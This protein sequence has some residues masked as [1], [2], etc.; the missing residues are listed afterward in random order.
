MQ[1]SGVK[2]SGVRFRVSV[3]LRNLVGNFVDKAPDEARDK[4]GE[5]PPE[6]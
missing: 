5:I 2:V 1:V 6:T 4:D 3:T